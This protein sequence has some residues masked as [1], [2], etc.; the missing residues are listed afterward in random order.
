M[1]SENNTPKPEDLND[2]E[3]VNES[4]ETSEQQAAEQEQSPE[5]RVIELEAQLALMQAQLDEAQKLER[6][7]QARA[8]AEVQNLR[9]RL[10]RDTDTARKFAL[11]RFVK[12]LLPV[13]DSFELGLNAMGDD[14]ALKS[15][16]D[17]MTL[18]QKQLLDVLQKFDVAVIDGTGE[19]Y[20]AELHEVVSMAPSDQPENTVI[21]VM[22]K[23]YT[24]NGRL[25][26]P[27]MVVVSK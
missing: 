25:V 16:R 3:Q 26:R 2:A 21:Q 14:E 5:V 23:G 17:G 11:E 19:P 10:E 13:L 18:T 27:A 6:E 12:E 9:K 24:L 22:Q 8:H 4:S 1:M 15:A 7:A 20:S